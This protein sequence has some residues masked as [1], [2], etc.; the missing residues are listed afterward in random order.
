MTRGNKVASQDT[1]ELILILWREGR[2]MV[3]IAT[4]VGRSR[5]AVAGL[6]YRLRA[7]GVD[8]VPR[9]TSPY[10]AG[11]TPR[12]RAK[13]VRPK[14]VVVPNRPIPVQPV[15]DPKTI[16]D[17]PLFTCR[18]LVGMNDKGQDLYCCAPKLPGTYWYCDY[19][20]YK[21]K[22][23]HADQSRSRGKM[24]LPRLTRP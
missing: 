13:S 19:H 21:L 4:E 2:S 6:I 3:Q 15:T 5:S 10:V 8:V 16:T 18:G 12:V 9:K 17:A 14:L 11:G 23:R 7:K 1:E 24:I 22:F 20:Q